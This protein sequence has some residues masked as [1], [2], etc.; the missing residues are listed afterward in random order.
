MSI[1]RTRD[2]LDKD[3]N[4][5]VMTLNVQKSKL[6]KYYEIINRLKAHI[7]PSLAEYRTGTVS[8]RNPYWLVPQLV[9]MEEQGYMSSHIQSAS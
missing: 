7:F 4:N 8:I 3:K 6:M 5:K 9:G 1:E 2:C